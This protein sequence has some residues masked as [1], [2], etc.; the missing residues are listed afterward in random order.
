MGDYAKEAH[1][2]GVGYIGSCCGSVACHV[3]AMAEALGKPVGMKRE[4]RSQQGKAMSAVEYYE[5]R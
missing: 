3:R 5:G 1:E 4:W 2:I